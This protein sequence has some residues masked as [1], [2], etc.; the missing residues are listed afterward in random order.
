MADLA[1]DSATGEIYFAG[2]RS[3]ST[4][5]PPKEGIVGVIDTN[6]VA[7]EV[8]YVATDTFQD[9]AIDSVNRYVVIRQK[10]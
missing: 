7:T 2:Y 4:G 3:S 6:G 9:L 8:Y 1:L 10:L 5:T